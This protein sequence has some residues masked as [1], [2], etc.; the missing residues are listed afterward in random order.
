M[1]RMASKWHNHNVTYC[2]LLPANASCLL[3]SKKNAS[4]L[5]AAMIYFFLKKYY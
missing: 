2:P 1:D 3:S 5:L 4:C